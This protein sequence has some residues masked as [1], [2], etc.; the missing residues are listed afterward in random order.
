[1]FFLLECLPRLVVVVVMAV[2]LDD[3]YF[4]TSSITRKG[5]SIS[6]SSSNIAFNIATFLKVPPLLTSVS[7]ERLLLLGLVK[8]S[9]QSKNALVQRVE[10][11]AV[12]VYRHR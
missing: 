8:D 6:S 7:G 2:L 10:H 12:V 1:M 4:T 11:R 5:S 9:C 3:L